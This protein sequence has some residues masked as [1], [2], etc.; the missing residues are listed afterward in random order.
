MNASLKERVA[1]LIFAVILPL[2]SYLIVGNFMIDSETYQIKTAIDSLILASPSWVFP[3]ILMYVLSLAPICAIGDKSL[4]KR[5]VLN[6]CA[7]YMIAI[8]VWILLPVRVDRVPLAGDSFSIFLMGIIQFLDPPTNC[9]PSMHVA[10][11]TLSALVIRD[12]DKSL[13]L[14]FLCAVLPIWY[15][16]VAVGQHW[17]V[18][19]IAGAALAISTYLMVLKGIPVDK[20]YFIRLHR[21]YHF[22]WIVLLTLSMLVLWLAWKIQ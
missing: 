20:K 2:I 14:I 18:D 5:W 1:A 15:S 9:F 6:V 21:G 4:L 13:G 11:A 7:M 17:A 22:V 19:G 16:T 3:Y 12:V 8:P 10:I